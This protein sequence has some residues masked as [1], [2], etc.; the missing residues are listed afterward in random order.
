[1]TSMPAASSSSA[2]F[3][4]IPRPP[5]TFSAL[6]TTKV[7]RNRSWRAGRRARR[8][9]RPRPPTRS[10]TKRMVAGASGTA[11]TLAHGGHERRPGHRRRDRA[12]HGEGPTSAWR[13]TTRRAAAG[14]AA[15]GPTGGAAAAGPRDLRGGEGGRTGPAHLH[16]RRRRRADPHAARARAAARPP[17]PGPRDRRGVPRLLRHP[18]RRGDPARE[19]DAPTGHLVPEGP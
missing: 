6:A 8:V 1:M 11:H 16:H 10:P 5:A 19:P 17:P 2:I 13:R 9:R 12:H 15:M 3:G 14:R 18:G 4:V 7:G